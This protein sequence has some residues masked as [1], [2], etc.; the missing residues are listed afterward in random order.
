MDGLIAFASQSVRL[1]T[2]ILLAALGAIFCYRSG[3]LNIG[4]EGMMLT[5]ALMGVV[6]STLT[7]QPFIGL[8]AAAVAGAVMGLIFAVFAVSFLA[9]QAVVGTALNL[10]SIGFTGYLFRLLMTGTGE[11]QNVPGFGAMPIP[12]LERIPILGPIVFNQNIFV[13]ICL[14]AVVLLQV[15]LYHTGFGLNMRATGE[16]PRAASAMG[17]NVFALRY[18]AV[19]ASGLL[20]GLGGAA[21]SIGALNLFIEQM[22]AGR[23]FIALAAVTFG[24]YDPIGTL[25]ASLVFGAADAL[26]LR[27]Q[28]ASTGIPYQYIQM[29]PYVVTLVVLAVVKGKARAPKSTGVR[30]EREAL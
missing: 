7:G 1:A 14:V 8:L 9:D 4:L 18:E 2:P 28:V 10:V 22:S 16:N 20:A 27:L 12:G 23:G 5:G 30:F 21:L 26:Q 13:Y 17:V 25:L 11:T 24:R 29:L 3:V 19:I 15:L 6:G